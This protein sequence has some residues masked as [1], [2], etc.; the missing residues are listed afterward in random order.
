MKICL[1][2]IHLLINFDQVWE[3]VMKICLNIIHL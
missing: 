3:W 2:I 1:N